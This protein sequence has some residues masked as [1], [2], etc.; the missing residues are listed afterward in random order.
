MPRLLPRIRDLALSG[1]QSVSVGNPDSMSASVLCC[2]LCSHFVGAAIHNVQRR[3]VPIKLYLD[4]KFKCPAIPLPKM[5]F[6]FFC[7]FTVFKNVTMVLGSGVVQAAGTG[8]TRSS[9]DKAV[10]ACPIDG[11]RLSSSQ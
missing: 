4:V 11:G 10:N 2:Q 7:Y 5:F 6:F 1:P 8:M 9:G 3:R